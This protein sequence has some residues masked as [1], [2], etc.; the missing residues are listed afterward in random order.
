MAAIKDKVFPAGR[1]YIGDLCYCNALGKHDDR[2][3]RICKMMFPDG[4][5]DDPGTHTIDGIEFWYHCTAYGDG[6][7]DSNSRYTFPVDAGIIGI[8]SAAVAESEGSYGGHIIEFARPFQ[9]Y[10]ANGTFYIG[11]LEI[12]TDPRSDDDYNE[13]EDNED[14]EYDGN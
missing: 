14:D 7:Y 3:D 12:D 13:D 10:Y 6:E 5:R 9:P 4:N 11:H 1:Y 2:W 8:V